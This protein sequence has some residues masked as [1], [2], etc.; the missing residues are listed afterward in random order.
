VQMTFTVPRE[1]LRVVNASAGDLDSVSE[2]SI[3]RP[4][5]RRVST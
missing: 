3:S 2:I 4:G 1:K 5:S